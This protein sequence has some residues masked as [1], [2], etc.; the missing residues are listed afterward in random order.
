M[1]C[2]SQVTQGNE[3]IILKMKSQKYSF[4]IILK[5]YKIFKIFQAN[6]KS[7]WIL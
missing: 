6:I 3:K 4:D 5:I 1:F 7:F 2:K